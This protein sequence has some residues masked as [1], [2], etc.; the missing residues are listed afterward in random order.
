MSGLGRT[1][2]A[3]WTKFRTVRGWVIGTLVAALVMAGVGL[4]A[5]GGGRSAC[6]AVGVGANGQPESGSG[7]SCQPSF[8]LGPDGELC[9][10]GR[11]TAVAVSGWGVPL[12]RDH[13]SAERLAGA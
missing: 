2:R 13:W 9:A 6:Q 12:G 3:E 1:V 11:Q 7:S 5:A 4:L 8:I 10:A